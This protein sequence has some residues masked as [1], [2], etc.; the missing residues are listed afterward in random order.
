[1]FENFV[2][3]TEVIKLSSRIFYEL[4]IVNYSDKLIKLIREGDI[5]FAEEIFLLVENKSLI[6]PF[7][8]LTLKSPRWL[9]CIMKT[10]I[11]NPVLLFSSCKYGKLRYVKYL[12]ENGIN[13][14]AFRILETAARYNHWKIVKYL[15]NKVTNV[16]ISQS[17]NEAIFKDNIR[18]VE[19]LVDKFPE[20]NKDKLLETAIIYDHLEVARLL[21]SKGADIN[22]VMPTIDFIGNYN[23]TATFLQFSKWN[24]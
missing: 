21:V 7:V 5:K 6:H 18:I 22:K 9:D 4:K 8:E 23:R 2:I 1:M 15:A 16:H 10:G 13:L 24:E 12:V 14:N 11:I 20:I 3:F 19:Y 17:I